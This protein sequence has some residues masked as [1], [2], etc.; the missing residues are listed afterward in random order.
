MT[1]SLEITQ[2]LQSY[3]AEEDAQNRDEFWNNLLPLVYK[4]LHVIANQEKRRVWNL[5]TL[6]ATALVNEA[7]LKLAHNS[8][9][10]AENRAHFFAVSSMAM[11]QILINYLEQKQAKKRGGD[12]LQVSIDELL[13]SDRQDLD[14][15]LAIS[16]AV[17]QLNEIDEKL[18]S[19]V[20]MRFFAG[21]TETE[22]ALALDCTERTV[23][24]N[25]TKAKALLKQILTHN[26]NR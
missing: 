10:S 22:I 8:E 19:L 18:S 9:L 21:M 7:Y 14:T 2:L 17:D 15:L 11:R 6:S 3:S 1:A 24:R 4:Q 23:R 25:W 12:W 5:D 16:Q 20:E 26:E 13:V